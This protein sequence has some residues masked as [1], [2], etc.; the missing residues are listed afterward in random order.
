MLLKY[1]TK[2]PRNR[3]NTFKV[4]SRLNAF[5]LPSRINSSK[6]R[7]NSKLLTSLNCGRKSHYR[8]GLNATVITLMRPNRQKNLKQYELK[9]YKSVQSYP[10]GLEI[11]KY[12]PKRYESVPKLQKCDQSRINTLEKISM[13]ENKASWSPL[14][15]MPDNQRAD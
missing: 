6:V 9:W 12:R 1:Y 14:Q 5:Q 2:T 8:S 11:V 7:V 13:G 15:P 10:K 4:P 3:I